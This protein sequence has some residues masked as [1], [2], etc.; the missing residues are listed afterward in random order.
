MKGYLLAA[1]KPTAEYLQKHYEE[2]TGDKRCL[3]NAPIHN[4]Q[5]ERMFGMQGEAGHSTKGKHNRIRGLALSKLSGTF[6][7][8]KQ[9]RTLRRKKFMKM[10]RRDRA[11]MA[12]WVED[13]KSDEGF[14]SYFNRKRF[15]IRV[16]R[17]C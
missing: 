2:N 3:D 13:H 12:D 1:G 11:Q 14:L 10:V 9:K 5:C 8:V 6:T 15:S 7:T 17:R 16:R 4:T